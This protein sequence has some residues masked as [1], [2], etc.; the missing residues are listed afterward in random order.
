MTVYYG[1]LWAS[2]LIYS[3]LEANTSLSQDNLA[4]SSEALARL[5]GKVIGASLQADDSFASA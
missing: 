3:R 2:C 1:E 4:T 5:R